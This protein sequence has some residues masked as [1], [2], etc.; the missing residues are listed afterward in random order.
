MSLGLHVLTGEFLLELLERV[1]AGESADW[2]YAEV[3]CNAE[4]VEM[5]G[6]EE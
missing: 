3:F 2:V 5:E 4:M 1:E 6:D